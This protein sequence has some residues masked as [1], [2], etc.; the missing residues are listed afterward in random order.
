[1]HIHF[2][3]TIT[4]T[5]TEVSK[6]HI[7]TQMIIVKSPIEDILLSVLMLLLKQTNKKIEQGV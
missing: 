3:H 5:L 2:V 1:M 6:L 4:H 7:L